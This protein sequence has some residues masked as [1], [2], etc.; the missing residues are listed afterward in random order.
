MFEY[1]EDKVLKL[2]KYETFIQTGII[3]FVT[4]GHKMMIYCAL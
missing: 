2:L 3:L 1:T 4:D